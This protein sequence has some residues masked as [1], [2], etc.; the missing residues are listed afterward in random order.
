MV[1]D[2][3]LIWKLNRGDRNALCRIYEKYR[4]DLLKLATALLKSLADAEDTVHDV[5]LDFALSAGEFR[6]SGSLKGYLATC[7]ANKARNKN[8]AKQRHGTTGLDNAESIASKSDRPDQWLTHDEELRQINDALQKLPY[9]QRETIALKVHARM[10]FRQIANLQNVSIATVQ[11]RYR[12]G[13]D[14]MRAIL[15][16]EVTR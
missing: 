14:K 11:S 7:V 12:C 10:K 1:E 9:E 2:K 15:N 4:D 16:G 3:L 13:L 8:Q 5:F 6:L